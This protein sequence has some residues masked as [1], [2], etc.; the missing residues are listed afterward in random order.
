[1]VLKVKY[2]KLEKESGDEM[3]Y[4]KRISIILIVILVVCACS[5]SKPTEKQHTNASS[6]EQTQISDGFILKDDVKNINSYLDYSDSELKKIYFAGGC[7]WGVEAYMAKMYGVHDVTSGYAN[8]TMEDPS[9]KDVIKGDAGFVEAV[10]VVYDPERV[11]LETLVNN[12]FLVIDPTSKN[13][14]GNDVGIQYRTGIYTMD[15]NELAKIQEIVNHQ[16][17]NY[18]QEI[19]TEVEPLTNFYLAEEVHQDY[20]EKNPNGYCHID[21]QIANQLAI[22]PIEKDKQIVESHSK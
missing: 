1:M 13:K 8:G 3:K 7:F 20:L 21:L 2:P 18:S 22:Q 4:W 12:L 15:E 5:T 14:Q 19:V 9:Y 16:Q 6:S 17:Q 10:E 11:H